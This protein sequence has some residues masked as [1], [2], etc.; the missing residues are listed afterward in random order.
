MYRVYIN[1]YWIV[2]WWNICINEWQVWW[3]TAYVHVTML[4]EGE[5]TCLLYLIIL[6]W[7]CSVCVVAM[8]GWDE[9]ETSTLRAWS[10]SSSCATS[11][12]LACAILLPATRFPTIIE[13]GPTSGTK[14]PAS[15]FFLI[16]KIYTHQMRFKKWRLMR[17]WTNRAVFVWALEGWSH[18]CEDTSGHY[19]DVRLPP[20]NAV[21]SQKYGC[22]L[23][24]LLEACWQV[25]EPDS[26]LP[27]GG[28][29]LSP[30]E[31][32]GFSGNKTA[33]KTLQVFFHLWRTT[34]SSSVS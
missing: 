19:R 22:H 31:R 2:Y 10:L 1:A 4:D 24:E 5:T 9:D 23:V 27:P 28:C 7:A 3:A 20:G 33:C 25:P 32:R 17:C 6:T 29:C 16:N 15:F 34:K 14:Q 11:R 8:S 21:W 18:R 13:A 30:V 12:P 26:R